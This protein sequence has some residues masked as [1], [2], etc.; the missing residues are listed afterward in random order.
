[1]GSEFKKGDK[2]KCVKSHLSGSVLKDKIYTVDGDSNGIYVK[3]INEYGD[4]LEYFQD[5][6][7]TAWH[8]E[9]K[10]GQLL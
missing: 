4:G 3:I 9:T 5:R 8:T 1:M 2:V 7:V 6:F 10:L